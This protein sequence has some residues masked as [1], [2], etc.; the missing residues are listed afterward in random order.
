MGVTNAAVPPGGGNMQRA[1]GNHGVHVT[2]AAVPPG[3]GN[4]Q[5]AGGNHDILLSAPSPSPPPV[6]RAGTAGG[7]E[8]M[9]DSVPAAASSPATSITSWALPVALLSLVACLTTA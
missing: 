7:D 3:G 1:G 8:N 6:D 2:N 5:R 9:Y 4:M